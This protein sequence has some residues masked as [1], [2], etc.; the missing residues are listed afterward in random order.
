MSTQTEQPLTVLEVLKR[1]RA[2]IEKPESWCQRAYARD[3]F[4]QIIHVQSASA[5]KW[6]ALG[7]VKALRP[8]FNRAEKERLVEAV[9]AMGF[10]GGVPDLND[11]T[12][13]PTVLRMFDL[14]I[15]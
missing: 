11:E 5:C 3:R 4:G 10:H 1:A 12:D 2:K 15:E 6:C 7:A 9:K 8:L 13:H 14:A